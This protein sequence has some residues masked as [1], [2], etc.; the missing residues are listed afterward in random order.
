[1]FTIQLIPLNLP[2]PSARYKIGTECRF[3]SIEVFHALRYPGFVPLTLFRRHSATCKVHEL[4]LPAKAQRNYIDCE[5]PIWVCGS[6]DKGTYPRQ[7][8]P[9]RIRDWKAAQAWLLTEDGKSK[10][11]EVHGELLET[12]IKD[13]LAARKSDLGGKAYRAYIV[14][15][16]R[17]KKYAS[18]K[19]HVFI[20]ELNTNFYENFI[21]YELA[22][23]A[24]TSKSTAV[25]KLR[26]FLKDAYRRDWILE[27]LR[28]K[29]DPVTAVYEEK[30]PYTEDE[31]AK[32]ME[33]AGNLNGGT[34]AY[35]K[36]PKTFQLFL[37]TML[38]TGMRVGDTVR[39]DP[40]KCIWSE[41]FWIYTYYPEKQKKGRPKKPGYAYLSDELKTAIDNCDWLSTRYPFAYRSLA[42]TSYMASEV[43]ERMQ[44]IGKNIGVKD[45][46]PHRMRDT[47]AVRLLLAGAMLEDVSKLLNHSSISVTETYYAS[48]VQPRKLRLERLLS[49]IRNLP[50]QN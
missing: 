47:F 21:T 12:C 19:N 45:C 18:S 6:T 8:I 25:A 20:R 37:R 2:I 9:G 41:H 16:E 43:Y 28:E 4:H 23:L 48:W 1:V 10:D 33:A 22:D 29:V 27:S 15:L 44:S 32:I 30:Q 5:C 11:A 42:E 38:E 34:H 49:E 24:E 46:R 14:L 17:L 40:T 36:Y 50:K 39:Y 7:A 3:S 13:Y 26:C 31:V 35:A